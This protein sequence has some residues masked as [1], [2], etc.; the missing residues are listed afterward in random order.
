MN[1]VLFCLADWAGRAVMKMSA[2]LLK[3]PIFESVLSQFHGPN[4][5]ELLYIVAFALKSLINLVLRKL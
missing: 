5:Y 1:L 2:I 3:Y 4:K